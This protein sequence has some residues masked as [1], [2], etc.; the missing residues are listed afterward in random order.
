MKRIFTLLIFGT[1][2]FGFSQSFALYKTNSVGAIT[3]TVTNGSTIAEISTP[4][5]Q[6]NTK[7]KIKNNAAS[8]QTFNVIRS[9][10]SQNPA[11]DL[12]T[13]P[14]N[15]TTYF[16]FGYSCFTSNVSTAGPGDYTVLLA[17]G[18]TS[19]TFPT[20]DNSDA[21]GQPFSIYLD[22]AATIGNYAVRYKVF[23]TNN[24]NDTVS[25]IITYNGPAGIKNNEGLTASFDIYPNPASSQSILHL[26]SDKSSETTVIVTNVAGQIVYTKKHTLNP[27]SNSI[28]LNHENLS[29]G[30]YSVSL[31]TNEAIVTKKLIISR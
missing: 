7:I 27:G 23:V 2:S 3:S 24:T 4:S 9:V 12:S 26:N 25:F 5:G 1:A 14:S 19:T 18:Q 10:V 17:A 13:T 6:T 20:S 28:T 22:E 21:N 31:K 11:L 30:I 29:S 16:C 15:P 8:T